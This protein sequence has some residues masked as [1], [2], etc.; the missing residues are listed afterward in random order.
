MIF[1]E[2]TVH[3]CTRGSFPFRL[4]FPLER[5]FAFDKAEVIAFDKA[6]VIDDNLCFFHF[7]G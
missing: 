4:L 1:T 5:S 2:R 6:E 7:P 3:S